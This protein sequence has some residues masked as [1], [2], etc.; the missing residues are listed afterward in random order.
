MKKK[1]AFEVH[2]NMR[3]VRTRSGSVIKILKFKNPRINRMENYALNIV[4]YSCTR[5][6]RMIGETIYLRIF[7]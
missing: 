1:N 3:Y 5:R 7:D 4:S 2:Y 6:T